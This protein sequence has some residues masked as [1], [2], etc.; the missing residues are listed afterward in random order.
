MPFEKGNQLAKLRRRPVAS[1]SDLRAAIIATYRRLGGVQA[2]V[3]LAEQN[4]ALFW[5]LFA[6]IIPTKQEIEHTG[7][8]QV[9]NQAMRAFFEFASQRPVI[10]QV[11]V[12]VPTQVQGN[13]PPNALPDAPPPADTNMRGNNCT[14]RPKTPGFSRDVTDGRTDCMIDASDVHGIA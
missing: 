10:Q 6:K 14:T 9:D 5:Q 4:P 13:T 11:Q 7:T 3:K 2:L 8:V 1:V 12:V